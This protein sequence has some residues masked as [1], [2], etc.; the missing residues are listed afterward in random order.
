MGIFPLFG[1]CQCQLSH[2]CLFSFSCC[3][4]CN[5]AFHHPWLLW[6]HRAPF[7]HMARL[8]GG[9]TALRSRRKTT[10][11]QSQLRAWFG[12][13]W[14]G[15]RNTIWLPWTSPTTRSIVSLYGEFIWWFCGDVVVILWCFYGDCVVILWWFYGDL[16]VILWWFCGDFIWWF[17]MVIVYGDFIWWLNGI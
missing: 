15:V 5:L 4:T 17:Y 8:H 9:S 11:A 6:A 7:E 12:R 14:I 3:T 1:L 16:M 13:I 10:A 2:A